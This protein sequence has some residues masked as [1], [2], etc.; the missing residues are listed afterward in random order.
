MA[1]VGFGTSRV[2][3]VL[4]AGRIIS[5]EEPVSSEVGAGFASIVRSSPRFLTCA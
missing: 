4:F 3:S 2:V 5:G 1:A